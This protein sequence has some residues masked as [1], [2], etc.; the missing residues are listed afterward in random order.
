M[1]KSELRAIIQD[2]HD[3]SSSIGWDD[4]TTEDQKKALKLFN[5]LV[6]RTNIRYVICINLKGP[7]KEL[8]GRTVWPHIIYPLEFSSIQDASDYLNV[9]PDPALKPEGVKSWCFQRMTTP[10]PF[11]I[12]Q[13]RVRKEDLIK[14]PPRK[15]R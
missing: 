8:E 15:R 5:E 9:S 10:K 1:N 11:S 3:S 6:K 7:A 14:A 13:P 12:L 4:L 2:P